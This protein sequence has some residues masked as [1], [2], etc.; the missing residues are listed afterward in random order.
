MDEKTVAIIERLAEK[1][2]VT[3]EYLWGVLVTQAPISSVTGLAIIAVLWAAIAYGWRL[4]LKIED[5]DYK[6]PATALM[7]CVSLVAALVSLMSASDIVNGFVS[8]EYWA[9]KQILK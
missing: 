3:A 6:F 7:A 9:L 8:P 1:L 2:G 4:S 5:E